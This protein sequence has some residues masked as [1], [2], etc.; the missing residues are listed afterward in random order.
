M[1]ASRDRSETPEPPWIKKFVVGLYYGA[2]HHD[3][4]F[5]GHGGI[6]RLFDFDARACAPLRGFSFLTKTWFGS[7][8]FGLRAWGRWLMTLGPLCRTPIGSGFTS[9]QV[10]L[11]TMEAKRIRAAI[12]RSCWSTSTFFFVV[13]RLQERF[14]KVAWFAENVA[15]ETFVSTM[16]VLFPD[17]VHEV[18]DSGRFI[19]EHRKLRVP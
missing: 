16:K 13:R 11:A 18:T 9:T 19:A 17:S 5:V 4:A 2:A 8:A 10:C 7:S 3:V 1:S 15:C 14:A 12:R 6:V